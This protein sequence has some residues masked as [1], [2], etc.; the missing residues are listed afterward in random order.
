MRKTYSFLIQSGHPFALVEDYVLG[1]AV[2]EARIARS[3]KNQY[4]RT[5][6]TLMQLVVASVLSEG[7][8][9]QLKET[10]SKLD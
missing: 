5:E 8:G 2:S 10:L 1:Y 4:L 9:K 6:M 3:V 7:A